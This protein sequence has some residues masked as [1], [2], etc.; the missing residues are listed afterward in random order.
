M[1]ER[2]EPA[3]VLVDV[4]AAPITPLDVLCASGT[5]YFGAPATP[6]VP[7]VQGVG[8]LASPLGD[9]TAGTPVWFATSAG[10]APGDGSMAQRAAV[11]AD[12]VVALP[13][14][15]D[16]V[17]AGALGLSAVAAWMCLTWR[18][19][20]APGETVLV[21]GAGGAVGETAV[22]LARLAGAGRV[23]ACA[24]S[25]SALDRARRHGADATVL[26]DGDDWTARMTAATD[27]G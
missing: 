9:L 25:A 10:M 1:G 11:T 5:S 24:R 13:P 23:V 22:Q 26:L 2:A 7:G 8:T 20:L 12:D 3:G 15:V 17:L 6:Y 19:R 16:P 4:L 21:L 18:G 27:G 14:G